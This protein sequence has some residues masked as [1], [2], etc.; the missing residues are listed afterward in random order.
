MPDELTP[1]I[2]VRAYCSG[3]FPMGDDTQPGVVRW[4]A[5]DP[6]GLLP[7]DD[8]FHVPSSLGR[9]VRQ[10]R[11]RVTFDRAFDRVIAA[12]ADRERTWITPRIR[13]AYRALH[14]AGRAHSV[15]AWTADEE[16][17][18]LAGGLYGVAL[19]GAFFGESMFFR[20]TNASKVA[21]VHLV[22]RLRRRGY[23][24]LDTQYST[25]HLEQFGAFEI[26]REEYQRRLGRALRTDATWGD[27]S[28]EPA[29]G[30]TDAPTAAL[31]TD[32]GRPT[33]DGGSV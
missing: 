29:A 22:R 33:V 8:R 16:G 18:N 27:S 15:E 14:R 23:R 28:G 25:P 32:G 20:E 5:P 30:E 21:L 9:I 13:R 2:L 31:Q 4:F 10:G 1:E 12:C 19:G 6:R 3:I 7:L 11:F 24:L 17:D 26:P